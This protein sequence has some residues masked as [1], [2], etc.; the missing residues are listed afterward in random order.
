MCEGW[1]WVWVW[2]VSCSELLYD[3]S[4]MSEDFNRVCSVCVMNSGDCV[5]VWKSCIV[6]SGDEI[7]VIF[8]EILGIVTLTVFK[9][10]KSVMLVSVMF[11]SATGG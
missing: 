9:Y 10:T 7:F 11:F 4:S 5:M 6:T 1:V 8:H 3:V 2:V